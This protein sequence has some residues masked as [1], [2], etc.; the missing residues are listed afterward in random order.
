MEALSSAHIVR[1]EDPNFILWPKALASSQGKDDEWILDSV[2]S[3]HMCHVK[4]FFI[5]FLDSQGFV[6][7]GNDQSYQI[8]GVGSV[9]I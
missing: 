9:K 5:A 4:E 8:E 2:C 1:D 6:L 7:M 3:F